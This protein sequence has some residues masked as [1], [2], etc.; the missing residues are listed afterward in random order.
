MDFDPAEKGKTGQI[1][2]RPHDDN[3]VDKIITET[4]EGWL[5]IICKKLENGLYEIEDGEIIFED[6]TFYE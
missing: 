4:Y 1:F 6:F 3:P 5:K 2:F